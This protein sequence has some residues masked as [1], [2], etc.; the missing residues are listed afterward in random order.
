MRTTG[1]SIQWTVVRVA[2]HQIVMCNAIPDDVRIA[3]SEIGRVNLPWCDQCTGKKDMP[4]VLQAVRSAVM[5]RGCSDLKTR[6]DGMDG[7]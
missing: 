6:W 3:E 4:T 7:E 1:S 5:C 2:H